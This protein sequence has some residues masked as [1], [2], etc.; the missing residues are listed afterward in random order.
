MPI[1][2]DI[3][4]PGVHVSTLKVRPQQ[5]KVGSWIV[6]ATDDVP[7]IHKVDAI[8]FEHNVFKI[9]AGNHVFACP[10]DGTVDIVG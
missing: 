9:K 10:S 4:K 6:S 5:V 2:D 7:G 8:Y 3:D 1:S